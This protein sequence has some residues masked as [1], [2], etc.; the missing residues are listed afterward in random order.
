[1]EATSAR[2]GWGSLPHLA[3]TALIV[4]PVA[5][6]DTRFTET[7]MTPLHEGR[8]RME[9]AGA[10]SVRFDRRAWDLSEE[11]WGRYL[12]L[13]R[14]IRGSVSPATLSPVEVL[15]IH[16]RTEA[17]RMKYARQWARMMREDTERILAFQ[18]AYDAAMREIDPQGKMIDIE[19]LPGGGKALQPGDRLLLFLSRDCPAC[20]AAA[21]RLNVLAQGLDLQL[22][23]YF[24]DRSTPD[25]IRKWAKA[26]GLDASRVAGGKI[27]LNHDPALL[28]RLLGI[29]ATVPETIRIRNG[30][31]VRLKL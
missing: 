4:T 8:S 6:S 9:A 1:M 24:V 31:M 28:G 21:R 5:L 17:E 29:D 16:A 27:T 12:E 3:L 13:M 25:Q 7:R 22:D 20:N 19:K 14:G 2:R 23:I 18:R 11:E 26:Q 30:K 10:P 15:G